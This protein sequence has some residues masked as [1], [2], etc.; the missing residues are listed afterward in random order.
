MP[1]LDTIYILMT[2]LW[3]W[4]MLYLTTQKIKTFI[5]TSHPMI[6]HKPNKQT[7]TPTWL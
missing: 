4:L 3:A 6:Y 5:M 7:P 2:H 1:Q